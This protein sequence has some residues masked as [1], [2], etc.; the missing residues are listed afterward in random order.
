M[1]L[2][3]R[4]QLFYLNSNVPNVIHDL[5]EKLIIPEFKKITNHLT[6]PKIIINPNKFENCF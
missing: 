6:Y 3:K 4:N 1:K 5:A 2:K